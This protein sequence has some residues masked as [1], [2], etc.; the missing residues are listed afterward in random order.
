VPPTIQLDE[1]AIVWSHSEAERAR[2][3]LLLCLHGGGGHEDDWAAW[4]PAIPAGYVAAALRGPVPVEQRWAWCGQYYPTA[5]GVPALSAA[6][7]GVLAWLDRQHA[8]HVSLVGWS[9]GGALAI[10]LMR[11]RPRRFDSAA[12]IAGFVWD[13]RP[14]AGVSARRPPVWYG[15]GGRDDVVPPAMAQASRRWLTAH[16]AARLVDL[17]DES[18]MLS[19]AFVDGAFRFI[20]GSGR[21][22]DAT[23]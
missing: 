10:H 20:A 9:Q 3:P 11:Q 4:F 1:N 13:R 8:G 18:H 16:T 5:D 15:M 14:H 17:P 21:L 19:G 22:G 2:R 12:V 23:I 7:R 6:A